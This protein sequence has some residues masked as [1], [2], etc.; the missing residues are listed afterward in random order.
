[1]SKPAGPKRGP[2]L[3]VAMKEESH[4]KFIEIVSYR[5][6]NNLNAIR[7]DI[8]SQAI[9]LLYDKEIRKKEESTHDI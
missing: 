1:M 5:I 2:T 8:I 7:A 6:L 9:E 4:K 3:T